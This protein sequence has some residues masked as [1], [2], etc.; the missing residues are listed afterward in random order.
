MNIPRLIALVCA[1]PLVACAAEVDSKGKD[2]ARKAVAPVLDYEGPSVQCQVDG[3]KLAVAIHV[4]SGGFALE[5][6]RT[7]L[8]DGHVRVELQLTSPAE[9]EPVITAE[10][11]M[12]LVVALD[13]GTEP[14]RVHVRQVQRGAQYLVPP[15]LALAAVIPR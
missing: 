1:L 14:V 2:A 6:L 8:V 12:K 5:L 10:Q 15:E 13:E 7:A 4:H 9:G 3:S 11:T